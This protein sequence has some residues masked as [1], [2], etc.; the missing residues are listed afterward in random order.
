VLTV[1]AVQVTGPA[2]NPSTKVGDR[3]ETTLAFT[4][5]CES[6]DCPSRPRDLLLGPSSLAL[7]A[8][9]Y[10]G[11]GP[12]SNTAGQCRFDVPTTV[13]LDVTK[14]AEVGGQTLASTF[15]GSRR[16]QVGSHCED[17]R[18]TG[19]VVVTQSLVGTSLTASVPGGSASPTPSPG[20]AGGS[21][22]GGEA[23]TAV[24]SGRFGTPTLT[25]AVAAWDDVSTSLGVLARNALIALLFALL[26]PFPA[27]LFNSTL[28]KNYPR[29]RRWLHRGREVVTRP[30]STQLPVIAAR[31]TALVL[32]TSLLNALL[33][34]ELGWDRASLILVVGLA[35]STAV[36]T[37]VSVTPARLY[38]RRRY[39]AGHHVKLFPLALVF[40]GFCVL[41]SRVTGY[42]PG[43][44]YGVIAGFAAAHEL[45]HNEKAR[46]SL[47][48][49]G[50]LLL[51]SVVSFVLRIPV[52]DAA[53]DSG[54][55]LLTIADTT[56]AALF[57]AGISSNVVGLLPLRFLT[58]EHIYRWSRAVWTGIFALNVFVLLHT[59][60]GEGGTATTSHTIRLALALF[61]G[62]GLLSV[63]FWGYFA[64]N[65]DKAQ[66]A[67]E[68]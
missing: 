3:L 28:E 11:S 10:S 63:L 37:L 40:A 65:P 2:S 51:V 48:T 56:L 26:L 55:A 20:A 54:G 35:V 50:F 44:L 46:L 13:T 8:S 12:P 17:G 42:Q 57:A 67:A 15:T 52:H 4:P 18:V 58:G 9:G 21:S 41:M 1:T 43:Y 22:G 36:V 6:G 34:P 7:T 53:V 32:L 59:L 47:G 49:S 38:L 14:T 5:T 29:I 19:R 66:P 23:A 25:T 27:T 60:A 45:A 62:F 39:H 68:A 64:L 30:P 24:R 16:S 31:F 61:L 33:D